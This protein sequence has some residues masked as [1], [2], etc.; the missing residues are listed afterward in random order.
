ME[1]KDILSIVER[2]KINFIDL[3]VVDIWGKWRHVTLARTNF[4][5]KTFYEGVGFDA[6]NLGYA[7]VE[8]SDMVLI[9]D[10]QTAFFEKIGEE[11]VLSLICDVYDVNSGKASFHDPRSI[12]KATLNEIG[13]VADEVFLGPEYEFHV[14]ENVRY[15]ISNNE[16]S[17][18]IDSK[19][20]FWN[21]EETGEYFI[22]KK[23]G[24]HRIPPFDTLMEV[25]N[26]IVKRL[27]EYGVPVKYHHH[28]V[29]TCQVEIELNFIS[30]LKAADY[31]LLVKHVARQVAKKFGLIV[32]FM[33]KPLYDEAGN[34]MHVHQFLVKNGENIFAGDKLYGLSTYALSYIAGLLK[35]APSIMAFTNPTTNSYRRLVPGY[36]APTNA[37]FALANRTAAIRIPAYVK[38]ESKKR[39][40]FRT[41]DASCNPYLA[42]S[43]MILAGVDGIR[44]KLDPTAEGFGPFERDL[45][46][47]DIKPLPYTLSQ[48]CSALKGDNE[49]LK[50]FPKQLIEHWI[51]LKTKEE[52]EMLAIPHP[53]EFDNYF[54]I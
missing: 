29:G 36:E 35:H 15:S 41:I 13:D 9:P 10:P 19:E 51:K 38:D 22:G 53:K 31:T 25:R 21:A 20:G 7:S 24:Y 16:I 14:F 50:V 18:K 17:L 46:N 34:G 8:N 23:K 32:T 39:I 43:A 5:E 6:S 44:E 54:D 26:E 52:R 45:Y 2:E 30:A 40:E 11:K 33:P 37:V 48:A 1:I 47:E 4:S 3:K 27:L 12:L 49:Y 42:F 28:E